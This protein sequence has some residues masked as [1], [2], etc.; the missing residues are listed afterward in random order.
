MSLLINK[1]GKQL[2]PYSLDETRSL[3][4]SGQLDPGDWAWLDDATDWV[5]LKDVPG[6]SQA[7]PAPVAGPSAPAT[8]GAAAE[9][10]MWRGHPSQVLNAS[11]YLFWAIVLILTLV[12]FFC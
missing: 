8:A 2:G 10:E 7:K 4:L 1:D 5:H 9:Q 6:F 3:V 11:I 12:V